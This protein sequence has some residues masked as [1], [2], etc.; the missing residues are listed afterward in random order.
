MES[1]VLEAVCRQLLKVWRGAW[2]AKGTGRAEAR[3]VDQDDHH[4][5]RTLGRAQLNDRR[6][7]VFR[8]FGIVQDQ[9]GARSIRNGKN[10]PLKIVLLTQSVAPL[11]DSK[12][13]GLTALY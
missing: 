8:V 5:G 10:V 13:G 9:A 7:L 6:V 2:T 4:I 12:F 11:S 1:V 3:V